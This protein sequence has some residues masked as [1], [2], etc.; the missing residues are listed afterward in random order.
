MKDEQKK[1]ASRLVLLVRERVGLIVLFADKLIS[2]ALQIPNELG[3]IM[4]FRIEY[5]LAC[6]R[7]HSCRVLVLD[8]I[9]P[10]SYPGNV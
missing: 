2:I 6:E 10:N 9:F 7:L 3:S 8:L 4:Q 5:V 1:A